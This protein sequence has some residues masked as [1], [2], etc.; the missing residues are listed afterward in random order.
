MPLA[1]SRKARLWLRGREEAMARRF[2]MEIPRGLA[3]RIPYLAIPEM[4]DSFPS[5]LS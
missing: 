4:F 2:F 5:D 3:G 1:Q